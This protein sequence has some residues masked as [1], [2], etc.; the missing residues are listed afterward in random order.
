MKIEQCSYKGFSKCIKLEAEEYEILAM[1]D[2]GPRIISCRL[3]EEVNIFGELC[4]RPPKEKNFCPGGGHRLW[5]APESPE[6]TYLP[7]NDEAH[8]RIEDTIVK[9]TSGSVSGGIEKVIELSEAKPPFAVNVRHKLINRETRP[10]EV[11]PWA[12]TI[13]AP[14]G[15]STALFK[16]KRNEWIYSPDRMLCFW[17]ASNL[18]DKRFRLEDD[19]VALKQL[20]DEERSFKVGL[21]SPYGLLGY[22]LGDTVFIKR[23]QLQ[24]GSHRTDFGVNLEM[25]TDSRI[26]ELETLGRL[27][28][29][30]YGEAIEHIEEWLITRLPTYAQKNMHAAADWFMDFAKSLKA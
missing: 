16:S 8:V 15:F 24:A 25:Y 30:G 27:T 10:L 28:V 17:P 21:Y 4:E 7:D 22:F 3:K 6:V 9:L 11:A 23:A 12:V 18:S 1:A 5:V 20:P 29:L 19:W 2:F 13:M 26:L 14:G